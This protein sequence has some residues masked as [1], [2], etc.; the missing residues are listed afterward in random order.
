MTCIVL[1][2]SQ[3]R[4]RTCK[5]GGY[6]AGQEKVTTGAMTD[7]EFLAKANV[8]ALPNMTLT[9]L[10]RGP[11]QA[12]AEAPRHDYRP[13]ARKPQHTPWIV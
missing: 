10:R 2:S 6:I 5:N 4:R 8:V 3:R 7:M 12:L 9:R 11:L 1:P 13:A